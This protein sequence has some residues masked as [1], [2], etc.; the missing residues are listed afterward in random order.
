MLIETRQPVPTRILREY[1]TEWTIY[2]AADDEVKQPPKREPA[3]A[4]GREKDHAA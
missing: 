3:P 1:P 4:G 2:S